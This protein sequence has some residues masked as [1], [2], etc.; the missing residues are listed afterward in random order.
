MGDLARGPAMTGADLGPEHQ[1]HFVEITTVV[2]PENEAK[3]LGTL[4]EPITVRGMIHHASRA[5]QFRTN[6]RVTTVVMRPTGHTQR[7]TFNIGDRTPV[8][9]FT[10]A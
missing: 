1:G 7:M 10:Q 3:G 6:L 4:G 5:V 8:R 9:V 2:T